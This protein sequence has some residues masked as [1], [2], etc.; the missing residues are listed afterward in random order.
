MRAQRVEQELLALCDRVRAK[1]KQRQWEDYD[2]ILLGLASEAISSMEGDSFIL[3]LGKKDRETHGQRLV[4]AAQQAGR[5]DITVTL[6]DQPAK[7]ESGVIVRDV[8]GRQV[9]DNSLEARLERMWPL[10][11]SQ[12]AER[13]GI[14]SNAAP[15]GGQS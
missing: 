2:A 5:A 3:E 15:S 9:W 13:L 10:L 6:G 1:I 12:I 7:I 4:A 14:Q 11:R 8:A